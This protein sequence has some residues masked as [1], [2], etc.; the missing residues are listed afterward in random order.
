MTFSNWAIAK[1]AFLFIALPGQYLGVVIASLPVEPLY[2][3]QELETRGKAAKEMRS[4]FWRSGAA[5]ALPIAAAL[6]LLVISQPL[7]FTLKNILGF[8]GVLLV[9]WSTVFA[10]RNPVATHKGVTL[11]ERVREA[12]FM[13][14][15]LSGTFMACVSAGM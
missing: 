15:F 12:L 5:C 8:V 11:P 3:E 9:A 2:L 6:A 7:V 10:I 14:M 13:G 1:A 4:L